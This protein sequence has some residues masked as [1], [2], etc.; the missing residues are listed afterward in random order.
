ME[1]TAKQVLEAIIREGL[2]PEGWG[3][4]VWKGQGGYGLSALVTKWT[5]P[6]VD[7]EEVLFWWGGVHTTNIPYFP[8]MY[9]PMDLLPENV[10]TVEEIAAWLREL[11]EDEKTRVEEEARKVLVGV[12]LREVVQD[13]PE[14]V[15]NEFLAALWEMKHDYPEAAAAMG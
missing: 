9:I 2:P 4:W 6:P 13:L 11:P 12:L 8:E 10:E 15:A 1:M 5:L 14:E 3:R 7:G